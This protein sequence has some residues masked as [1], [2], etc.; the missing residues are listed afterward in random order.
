MR[1]FALYALF[2]FLAPFFI[3]ASPDSKVESV[4][5]FFNSLDSRLDIDYNV[6]I[7]SSNNV[8]IIAR[9]D[10]TRNGWSYIYSS[11]LRTELNLATGDW[12][13]QKYKNDTLCGSVIGI[14]CH[15]DWI[16]AISD[17][18]VNTDFLADQYFIYGDSSK[19]VY[20][21]FSF[22]YPIYLNSYSESPVIFYEDEIELGPVDV[23]IGYLHNRADTVYYSRERLTDLHRE[24]IEYKRIESEDS[25]NTHLRASG[26][27]KN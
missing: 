11:G 4:E 22:Y 15:N 20:Q 16:S 13:F 5:E 21:G 26:Q 18:K 24:Y 9:K 23:G 6:R 2:L 14:S 25:T 8:F 1:N 7:D 10:S 3:S 19:T 17:I 12:Y 27:M